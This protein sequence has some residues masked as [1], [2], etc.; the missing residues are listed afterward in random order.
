[1]PAAKVTTYEP[2]SSL[3]WLDLDAAASERVATMLRALE[4]PSTLDAL[5]LGGVRDAFAAL[6]SPG[7][8]TIQTRLRYFIFLPWIFT[9][10]ESD[11][12]TPSGFSSRLRADEVR[13]IDCLCHLGPNNG[14]IG[15][16][17]GAQLERFPSVTYWGGL[18]SWGVRRLD[19]PLSEYGKRI[20]GF[21]RQRTDRDDDGNTTSRHVSMWASMPEPPSDFLTSDLTFELSSDE[22]KLIVDQIRRSHPDSLLALLCSHPHL[23]EGTRYPWDLPS[24]ILPPRLTDALRHARCFS[25]LTIGPQHAYNVLLTRK[26]HEELRWDTSDLESTERQ[27]IDD[28]VSLIGERFDELNEWVNQLPDFWAFLDSMG[29][30]ISPVTQE[31]INFIV[32]RAVTN[33]AGFV[34]DPVVQQRIRE[35]EVRLKAGRARLTYRSPL[36]NWKKK[37]FGAP[38]NYRW[39]I[40]KSYLADIAAGIAEPT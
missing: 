12:V 1:M 16:T 33:P 13:L 37:P 24:S 4:E 27:H 11:G 23:A 7:T 15:F 26:A 18:G 35:R 28:W 30:V 38:L 14:V 2:S 36:E 9:G 32:T 40:T 39:P 19:L 10:L 5:G 21:G 25:E 34:D 22:A 8:S 6:L 29:E 31:F 20:S 17:A 3:G